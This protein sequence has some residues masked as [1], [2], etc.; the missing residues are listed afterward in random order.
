MA[1]QKVRNAILIRI[2]VLVEWIC[3]HTVVQAISIVVGISVVNY[4]IRIKV[5]KS[6]G[7]IGVASIERIAFTA[8]LRTV[9]VG[10]L[11]SIFDAIVVG[12][13]VHWACFALGYLTTVVIIFHPVKYA[14][15]I[16]VS[17]AA[18]RLAVVR[19]R[20]YAARTRARENR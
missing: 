14:I 6:L 1:F 16:G 18:T 4:P 11:F 19:V 9:V 20:A 8:I 10:I 12:I 2:T 3:V 5:A 15:V 13:N 7:S 17:A